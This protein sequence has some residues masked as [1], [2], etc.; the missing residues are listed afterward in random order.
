[1]HHH[2]PSDASSLFWFLLFSS[3]PCWIRVINVFKLP[4]RSSGILMIN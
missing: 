1:L 3:F 2:R 4:N